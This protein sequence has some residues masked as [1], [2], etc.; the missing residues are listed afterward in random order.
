MKNPLLRLSTL[1]L[2]LLVSALT[3]F[4]QVVTDPSATPGYDAGKLAAA[5]TTTVIGGQTAQP[6][7]RTKVS[8]ANAGTGQRTAAG[9]LIPVDNTFT[10]VPR[11]DDGSFGPIDLGFTF[12]LYG[13]QYTQAWIN[14]NGNLT[15]TGPNGTYNPSGFPSNLPMVAGFWADEDTRL[16]GPDGVVGGEIHYKLNATNLIVSWDG[17]G[18]FPGRT[19]KLNT[20]QIIIGSAT[21]MLLG[22]GQNVSLRYGDMQWTTGNASGG[23]GGFGGT[24]ATVGINNGNGTDFVQVGRFDA[25]GTAYDGPGGNNDGVDYLDNQ[26]YGFYVSNAGNVPPSA[27]NLPANNTVNV[28]CGQTVTINPQFLAPEVNQTVTVG[29]NLGGLCN[30]T[31]NTTSGATAGATI[32]IT[33][34]VCNSGTHT[35]TL[36]AT[37]NGVPAQTTTVNLTVVVGSC[38]DV[39]LAAAV[40]ASCAGRASGSI[41]LT[42][43]NA[44]APIRYAW[45]NG[46]TTEDLTNVAAGT[47]TVNV[48]DANGCTATGT[49]TVGANPLPTPTITVT[50]SSTV[51]TGGS[52]TTLYL[53]YGPQSATLAATGGVSYSWSP[54]AG[55][56]STTSANPVFTATMPGT[57]TY[58]VT[59]TN[60]F[61]CTATASVTITVVDAQ[62]DKDKVIVCHNGHYICIAPAAV[63]EHLTTHPGDRL[64][65]CATVAPRPAPMAAGA[66]GTELAAYPNPANAQATVSFRA[67][68]DGQ[69]RMDVYNEMGQLVT[70]I[71]NGSVQ[72][73]QL[74]AVSLKTQGLTSG[75]YTCR[76]V[77]NGKAELVRLVISK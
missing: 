39:Q 22:P 65:A 27:S 21:D 4:G 46:A 34:S 37:D 11:N 25:P 56:S 3:G 52:P 73:G 6:K 58:T 54:A 72:G 48:T 66:T 49:Y 38:C 1:M 31:V 35:I 5:Q 10:A 29:V 69:A 51:Y 47:Y 71:Y 43:R 45:S 50:P 70:T 14:T 41:D 2:P 42:V 77:T 64:G 57:Y 24:P 74:Y 28:P 60:R 8:T 19:D 75:L 59:A 36:T 33:G 68:L 7:A 44:T 61:G 16:G 26:C 13:S 18:Y 76:L 63:N 40:A 30:T 67:P 23:S 32:A 9:C 15:F 17:V 55:L 20:F 53:G 12:D 62:C